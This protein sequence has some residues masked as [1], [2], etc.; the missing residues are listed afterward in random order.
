M[1][2]TPPEVRIA[3]PR[4]RISV[5]VPGKGDHPAV[6]LAV[7]PGMMV[8]AVGSTTPIAEVEIVAIDR[9]TECRTSGLR[10]GS[11]TIFFEC[12]VQP[13]AWD[14]SATRI[15]GRCPPSVF[16]KL[17]TAM[18]K[19]AEEAAAG[20]R[21]I[22]SIP[23]NLPDLVS[24]LIALQPEKPAV[25]VPATAPADGL[26]APGTPAVDIPAAPSVSDD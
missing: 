8:L 3:K 26:D 21:T 5:F 18:Q 20:K 7:E 19:I 2:R 17:T 6:V 10:F 9:E 23:P 25:T 22:R 13:T 11:R 16:M 24:K 4:D 12:H 15:F 14:G 1:S